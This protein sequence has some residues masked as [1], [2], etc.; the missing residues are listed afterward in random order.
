VS[1]GEAGVMRAPNGAFVLDGDDD[2]LRLPVTMINWDA[3]TAYAAWRS[4]RDGLPWQ[5]IS[6]MEHEKALRGADGRPF[7]WGHF[8]DPT[9]C[10]MRL[11]H[12]NP[13]RALRSTVDEFPIDCSVYGI[14]GLAANVHSWCRDAYSPTGPTVTNHIPEP[15]DPATVVGPGRDGVHRVMKGGSFRDDAGSCRGA[16]RDAP[17]SQYRDTV[18]GLRISRPFPA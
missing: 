2:Q 14:R 7:P 9:F 16:Y 13:G 1:G 6:E 17:P 5:L 12:S 11:S 8:L 18:L 3:A 4:E 15:P 10:C